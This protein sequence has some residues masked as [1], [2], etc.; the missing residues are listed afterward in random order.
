MVMERIEQATRRTL[1][2]V[3]TL[4]VL[5][6]LA[7]AAVPAQP[8]SAEVVKCQRAVAKASA[9]YA[10]DRAKALARCEGLKVKGTLTSG[11]VC[12]SEA[13]TAALIVKAAAKL[14]K[15]LATGCG[16]KDKICGV[17]PDGTED[18]PSEIGFPASC[19]D[20]ADAGCD[21]AL[22]HCGDLGDCLLCVGDAAVDLE[23]A[24]AAGD[25]V[26]GT[27]AD[28]TLNKCQQ[29]I[30][31]ESSLLLQQ[32]SKILQKCWD[33]RLR[34]QHAAPC[35]DASAPPKSAS[36]KAFD[37]LTKAE[38]KTATLLCRA[39]GGDDKL[40]GG[41][42][43]P[44]VAAI[45]FSTACSDVAVPSSGES[46]S[47]TGTIDG[48]AELVA[49]VSCVD[50]HATDCTDRGAVPAVAAYPAQCGTPGPTP[51][52]TP[53]P[54]PGCASLQVTIQTSFT[55]QPD[56]NFVA[57][58]STTLNYPGPQLEIP[59]SGSASSVGARVTNLTG[60]GGSLVSAADLNQ[61]ADAFDDRLNVGM[62]NT[63]SALPPGQ[64]VRVDFDCRAGEPVP[65]LASFSCSATVST[66]EGDILPA[67][68]SAT[69]LTVVP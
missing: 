28:K 9:K 60:V 13:K 36:R 10:Q 30:V 61:V 49:C 38:Q 12:E 3:C 67:T 26:P 22:A 41:G 35:P 52:P 5:S 66:L 15:D 6:C 8:A 68:C 18:T 34:G 7:L 62:I 55:V 21:G 50:A 46:C 24:Q 57:G 23:S 19:H 16:G 44:S 32:R 69:D 48:V 65:T 27:A 47:A 20:L 25:L 1:A 64:F 11:T 4:L 39:C 29:A 31:K 37:D 14:R 33:L 53:T 40:C 59:G 56:P 54:A 63:G 43:D 58:I 2:R 45:G 42:D 51:T 17:D